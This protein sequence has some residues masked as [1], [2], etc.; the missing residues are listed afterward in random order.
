MHQTK[1]DDQWYFGMTA[2]LL[3]GEEKVVYAEA[4]YQGIA[5]RPEMAGKTTDCRVVMRPDKRRAL[6][7]HTR[8]KAA[9]S[10]RDRQGPHPLQR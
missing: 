1:K 4:G 2:E 8:S 5:N 7:G 10:D 9:R 3:H 6:T